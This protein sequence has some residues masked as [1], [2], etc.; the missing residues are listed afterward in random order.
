LN[1]ETQK[2]NATPL[3][4]GERETGKTKEKK[5]IQSETKKTQL[6]PKPVKQDNILIEIKLSPCTKKKKKGFQ[7]T[8]K[9]IYKA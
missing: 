4:I 7:R 6:K 5:K 8:I 3:S 2:L 9:Y 1:R